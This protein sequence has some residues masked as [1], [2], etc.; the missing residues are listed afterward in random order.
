[1]YL[2]S[3]GRQGVEFIEEK[4]TRRGISG[5]LKHLSYIRLAFSDVHVQELRA[6][7][8]DEVE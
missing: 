8:A 6:L 5:A 2:S 4:H 1:M 7:H 3:I